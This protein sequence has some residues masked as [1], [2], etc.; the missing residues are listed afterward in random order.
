MR[1]ATKEPVSLIT[2]RQIIRSAENILDLI[3]TDQTDPAGRW[4]FRADG[5]KVYFEKSTAADWASHDSALLMGSL[6]ATCYV[7]AS[8][9]KSESKDF[10]Q[11]LEHLGY[12]VWV[13]DGTD[14]QVE[15]QA[16]IDALPSSGGRIS[17]LEGTYSIAANITIP[18]N[19]EIYHYPGAKLVLTD[20]TIYNIYKNSDFSGG[21]TRIVLRGGEFDG[22]RGAQTITNHGGLI[23]FCKVTDSLISGVYAHDGIN[24]GI[25]ITRSQR[26]TIENSTVENCGDDGLSV[27]DGAAA[28][29]GAAGVSETE[30]IRVLNCYS[31]DNVQGSSSGFEVDDGPQYVTFV[32]CIAEGN[33]TVGYNAGFHVHKH[34]NEIMPK[35]I[36]FINCVAKNN[37]AKGFRVIIRGDE[38]Q[39]SEFFEDIK[40]IRC[41]A[42]GNGENP[43]VVNCVKDL[44][45]D[46]CVAI[47][48][49]AIT[50]GAE[51]G[52]GMHFIQKGEVYG[53]TCVS[54]DIRV[55]NSFISG[56][57]HYGMW[58]KGVK[59]GIIKNN[60]VETS[61]YAG[62]TLDAQ[63]LDV[64]NFIIEGNI[65]Y[66]NNQ[67]DQ[68]NLS[69][70]GISLIAREKD[71]INSLIIGN[72]CFDDQ[73]IKTQRYGIS[74]DETDEGGVA[75]YNRFVDNVVK[76]NATAGIEIEY[77][78]DNIVE[79]NEGYVTE[80]SGTETFSGDG[81]TV[82]FSFAHGLAA[83]PTHV[84]ISPTSDDAA[85]DWKW[86]ADATNITITFMTAPASGTNN[87]SFSWRAWV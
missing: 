39:G 3:E 73:G 46:S 44:L 49:S 19:T 59:N 52:V 77:Q 6:G 4:R 87:I 64:E 60:T 65:S 84:E 56:A 32:N 72:R 26:I 58:I 71:I 63:T 35:H 40:F 5:N 62:I 57:K 80:N 69:R 15:I 81:T 45:V 11:L 42:T 83:T 36:T 86:S 51:E 29:G 14:D 70:A 47:V 21:N 22:N 79:H 34:T 50:N 27:S 66:N 10:A 61:Y 16:A 76:G 28:L 43:F 18:S 7:V 55:V 53:T 48:S 31:K 74:T 75:D 68:A 2:R 13:C 12:P 41:I 30:G 54:R 78:R 33:S 37:I 17:I 24:H 38:V 85:G 8:D 9:A 25:E 67:S 82:S 1:G 20:P 23:H